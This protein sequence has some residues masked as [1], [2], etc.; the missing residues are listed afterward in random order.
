MVAVM[1][2]EHEMPFGTRF[3]HDGGTEFRLWAPAAQQVQLEL[4]GKGLLSMEAHPDGWF[5]ILARDASAGSRYRFRIDGERSVTDP[6]SRYQPLGP[7]G[8]SEVL[9]PGAW[10]WQCPRWTGRPEHELVIEEIHVGAFSPQGDFDGVRRRLDHF[11]ALGVTT[12]ELM[13]VAD[14]PGR[15]NW[16][17]DM[18]LPFAPSARYGGPAGLKRLVDEAHQRGLMVLLDVVYNHFGPEGNYLPAYA[19][20]VLSHR[21]RTPWGAA[22]NFDGPDS[23]TV[24][25]FFIHNA[26]YWLEEYR[27]DGLRLDAVHAIID[28]SQPHLLT[29]LAERVREGPGRERHLHLI[30]END[31]NEAWPLR[32]DA[33]DMPRQYNAQWNDDFHHCMHVLLTAETEGYYADYADD[34]AG[35]LARVLTEGFAWQGEPSAFRGGSARGEPSAHL[36]PLSFIH[37]LQNHDQA[38]NRAAG[39]RITTLANTD[40]LRAATALLL[41]A[42]FPP[43]LFMGQE[44]GCEQPFPYFCDF[45]GSLADAVRQGRRREFP[46]Q[47]AARIPDPCAESTF[48]SAVLDW[49]ATTEDLGQRWL[50]FHRHLL[51]LRQRNV[52]PLLPGLHADVVAS[53]PPGT[54]GINAAWQGPHGRLA[55]LF[56]PG[57]P[58]NPGPE[59]AGDFPRPPGHCFFALPEIPDDGER[60]E[61]PGWGIAWYRD[62]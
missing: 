61:L 51:E 42:P 14:T 24:R 37:F 26:L 31:A 16:G 43:L 18:V 62:P 23:E 3:P 1:G 29:E 34:P 28:D 20:G 40:A 36:P 21:H 48:R 33:D 2:F 15:W 19:P 54:T 47:Q 49:S 56:N 59:C 45:E 12:L 7:E 5:A 44:W 10:H 22:I 41:L 39:E 11:V 32:R 46:E 53:R 55:V 52:C 50:A 57:N 17:Y 27:L 9:D 35:H 60:I 30:L 4:E 25:A 6:A 8:P 13:P 38:G 58:V